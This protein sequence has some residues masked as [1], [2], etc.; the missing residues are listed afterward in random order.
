MNQLYQLLSGSF[1]WVER[2]G[3][4]ENYDMNI[5]FL[6]SVRLVS[7]DIHQSGTTQLNSPI[8]PPAANLCPITHHVCHPSRV[9]ENPLPCE[10]FV[11]HFRAAD[12]EGRKAKKC[13]IG[14]NVFHLFSTLYSLPLSHLKFRNFFFLSSRLSC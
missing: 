4:K 5:C 14:Q 10:C 1:S 8:T 11:Q 9:T 13:E 6:M 7:N 2:E 3:R 12:R